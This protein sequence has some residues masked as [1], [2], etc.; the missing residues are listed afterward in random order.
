MSAF[1]VILFFLV[2]LMLAIADARTCSVPV[3]GLVVLGA[4]VLIQ[5]FVSGSVVV[6]V[7]HMAMGWLVFGAVYG[8][9]YC[10]YRHPVMGGGDVWLFG[11][12]GGF[13]GWSGLVYVAMVSGLLCSAL[14]VIALIVRG[15]S[16]LAFQ[17]PFVP[18]MFVASVV[19]QLWVY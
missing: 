11:I 15:R 13:F 6:A 2:L 4:V 10:L 16:V 5:H 17:W 3:L 8:L 7:T 9:S 19:Y 18:F 14:G 1:V 12:L